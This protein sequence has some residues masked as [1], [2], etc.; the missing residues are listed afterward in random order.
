MVKSVS[1][2]GDIK[3]ASRSVTLDVINANTNDWNTSQLSFTCGK[4]IRLYEDGVELFRGVL[5]ETDVKQ[6]GTVSLTAYDEAKYLVNN[7]DSRVFKNVK[8]SSAITTLCKEF[9]VPIG[10]IA[11]TGHYIKN[12]VMRERSL[13]DIFIHALSITKEETGRKYWMYMKEGRLYL[14]E[15]YKNTVN[16]MIDDTYNLQTS[17]KKTSIENLRNSVKLVAGD[18]EDKKKKAAIKMVQDNASISNYGRMQHVENVGDMK[19]SRLSDYANKKLKELNKPEIDIDVEVIGYSRIISGKS[20]F[21]T[22]KMTGLSGSYYVLQDTHTW[23]ENG[24]HTMKLTL[25]VTDELPLED[26]TYDELDDA[27][28]VVNKPKTTTKKTTK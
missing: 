16:W 17:S 13:W 14:V 11:D 15:R 22:D 27:N 6:D 10:S 8:A 4:Q 3:Q 21:V 5:F 9:G 24:V 12:L 25:S 28:G 20:V 18:L 2:T 19:S 7:A 26:L 1:W 23:D